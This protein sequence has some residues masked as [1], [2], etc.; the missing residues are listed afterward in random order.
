M[1]EEHGGLLATCIL[2]T[3]V[4]ASAT[5]T[6]CAESH[7]GCA[8]AEVLT[9]QCQPKPCTASPNIYPVCITILVTRTTSPCMSHAC[10]HMQLV[11]RHACIP[12]GKRS[13]ITGASLY[14]SSVQYI[15]VKD[16]CIANCCYPVAVYIWIVYISG[17]QVRCWSCNS[18]AAA[19]LFTS[20]Q[21]WRKKL[22]CKFKT[23]MALQIT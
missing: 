4:S 20:L 14:V 11:Y 6:H 9:T 23:K 21:R 12:A 13:A 10:T 1:L 5:Y 19:Y 8:K 22:A 18:S 17:T 3:F 7:T 15:S 2:I 16:C